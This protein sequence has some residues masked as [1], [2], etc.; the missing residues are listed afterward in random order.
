MTRTRIRP[1]APSLTEPAVGDW[2]AKVEPQPKTANRVERAKKAE[3]KAAYRAYRDLPDGATGTAD[4]YLGKCPACDAAINWGYGFI[5]RAGE[6]YHAQCDPQ[7]PMYVTCAPCGAEFLPES[8]E[9]RY[10]CCDA[11]WPRREAALWGVR[12]LQNF[13]APVAV[14]KGLR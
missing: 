2:A 12:G 11:C 1:P 10:P 5:V 8:G 13:F 14:P 6:I 3:T 7:L 4:R 9:N